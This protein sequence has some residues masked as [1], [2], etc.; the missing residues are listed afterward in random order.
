ML[1]L[2]NH[3][4]NHTSSWDINPF[5]YVHPYN[6]LDAYL[7][8]LFYYFSKQWYSDQPLCLELIQLQLSR[9]I[10]VEG[11][12]TWFLTQLD[13]ILAR[14]I[15]TELFRWL[16]TPS[17]FVRHVSRI[18]SWKLLWLDKQV[19]MVTY[20]LKRNNLNIY[21]SCICGNATTI[22]YSISKCCD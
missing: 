4:A 3:W 20:R 13:T 6:H 8:I 15:T 16:H 5:N 18:Q 11:W 17:C 19:K 9:Y 22:I 10:S 1:S 14:S 12:E 2:F 7:L 21:V